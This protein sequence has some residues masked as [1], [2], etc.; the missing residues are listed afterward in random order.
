MLRR[1]R[2]VLFAAGL[3]APALVL[4]G[5]SAAAAAVDQDLVLSVTNGPPGTEVTAS[6]ASC[7]SDFD[8]DVDRYLR[9]LLIS[10]TAP[11]EL[12]AGIGISFGFD[13]SPATLTVPD[14]VDDSAP[15]VIEA[16]CVTYSWY[17]D[18]E[19]T[20]PYDPVS[21]D[22]EPGT[23]PVT[24]TRTISRTE[25]L[26]GQALSVSATGCTDGEYGGVAVFQGRDLSGRTFDQSV[27][28]G[29]AEIV[30][31]TFEAEAVLSNA[32]TTWSASTENG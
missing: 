20:E 1:T 11:N 10:G 6:S 13:D 16:E 32:G 18:V 30:G 29:G 12:L 2:S 27:T 4:G 15:A 8:G 31:G 19:T 28:E 25:L 24:Q 7:V 22:I 14:W 3:L 26:A 9:V 21:F 5:H 23:G 17:D